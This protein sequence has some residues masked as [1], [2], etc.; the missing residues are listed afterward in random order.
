LKPAKVVAEICLSFIHPF[1]EVVMKT[2]VAKFLSDQMFSKVMRNSLSLSDNIL[3]EF[4]QS[5]DSFYHF[6]LELPDKNWRDP[7][8][9]AEEVFDIMNNPSRQK[10]RNN[11]FPDHSRSLSVGDVVEVDGENFVC[12]PVGWSKI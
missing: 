6:S 3:S 11:Y 4:Y 8:D 7:V 5:F 10:E 1:D 2:V 9:W 12:S